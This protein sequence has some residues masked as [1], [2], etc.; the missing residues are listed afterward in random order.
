MTHQAVEQLRDALKVLSMPAEAQL[1]HV[2]A[3]HADLDEIALEFD[4]IAPVRASLVDAGEMTAAQASAIDAVDRQLLEMS[5]AG[6]SRWTVA[7]ASDGEDWRTLRQLALQ[8]L[9]ALA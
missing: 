4:D 6:P 3:L 2:G 5:D 7:A 8:A 9:E 1:Q